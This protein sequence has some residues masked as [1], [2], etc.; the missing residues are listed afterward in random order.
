MANA[1]GTYTLV[2]V[3]DSWTE[4]LK[5]E[6]YVTQ[7][8]PERKL[9]GTPIATDK[10]VNAQIFGFQGLEESYTF[11]VRLHN[12]GN[13]WSLGS[14]DAATT[15]GDI[16]EERISGTE[17]TDAEEQLIW[18]FYNIMSSNITVQW[19]LEGGKFDAPTG[20]STEFARTPVFINAVRPKNQSENPFDFEVNI[21][22]TVGQRIGA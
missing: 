21:E 10:P 18:L 13:D 8:D 20:D 22:V 1:D 5:M 4:D 12:T 15:A 7:E 3:S 16:V 2:A 19:Y 11:T 14:Y 6:L 17:V 9:S